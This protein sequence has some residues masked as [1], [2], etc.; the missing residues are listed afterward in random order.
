VV[1][2]LCEVEKSA[3]C[4]AHA[5]S[6]AGKRDGNYRRGG[7]T[8]ETDV[9]FS[10]DFRFQG[11]SRRFIAPRMGPSRCSAQQPDADNDKDAGKCHA[12][13]G[14]ASASCEITAENDTR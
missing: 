5:G 6:P 12:N 1:R 13:H 9:G 8:K 3:E 10:F 11:K 14:V 4:T 7:R 2:L